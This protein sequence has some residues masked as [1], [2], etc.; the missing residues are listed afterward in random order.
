MSCTVRSGLVAK[1][2]HVFP[3]DGH[4]GMEAGSN[5]SVTRMA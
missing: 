2:A 5:D 1:G 4:G 3:G